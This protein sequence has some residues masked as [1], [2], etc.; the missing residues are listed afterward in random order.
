MRQRRSQYQDIVQEGFTMWSQT[1]EVY[2]FRIMKSTDVNACCLEISNVWDHK[3]QPSCTIS[4]WI[5]TNLSHLVSPL[6]VAGSIFCL[7]MKWL[8]FT[9]LSEAIFDLQIWSGA[10]S[11]WA[12]PTHFLPHCKSVKIENCLTLST[13]K[14]GI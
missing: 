9:I 3:V 14:M 2:R 7:Q 5:L 13:I 10:K 12:S 4:W 11:T 6:L 8:L 1:L